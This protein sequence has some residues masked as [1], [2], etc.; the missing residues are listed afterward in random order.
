MNSLRLWTN[1]RLRW[2]RKCAKQNIYYDDLIRGK[3]PATA[4]YYARSNAM[5]FRSYMRDAGKLGGQN[6][7]PRL[8]N[9]RG[10]A[11]VLENYAIR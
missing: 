2:T 8:S 1:S 11:D 10:M 3:S 5:A 4:G 9:D 6:K 7:V